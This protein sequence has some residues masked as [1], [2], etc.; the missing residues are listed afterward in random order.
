MIQRRPST[1][2]NSRRLGRFGNI[3]R[4][5]TPIRI[6]RFIEDLPPVPQRIRTAPRSLQIG[7]VAPGAYPIRYTGIAYRNNNNNNNNNNFQNRAATNIRNVP[8][9]V[10]NIGRSLSV[11]T[12]QPVR[13][14]NLL[15]VPLNQF[16]GQPQKLPRYDFPKVL[17]KKRIQSFTVR[18]KEVQSR[19]VAFPKHQNKIL[20]PATFPQTVSHRNDNPNS[21]IVQTVP[22][23][24]AQINIDAGDGDS[25]TIVLQARMSGNTNPVVKT[26]VQPGQG[27]IIP[28]TNV[29]TVTSSDV[30][31]SQVQIQ[32]NV[33]AIQPNSALP[34]DT[35]H[36]D[37]VDAFTKVI[38]SALVPQ[39]NVA[40]SAYKSGPVINNNIKHTPTSPIQHAQNAFKT[41]MVP[42]YTGMNHNSPSHIPGVMMGSRFS[43]YNQ[44]GHMA[45]FGYMNPWMSPDMMQEMMFGDTT[46]PPDGMTT[47]ATPE[48]ISST[49]ITENT[50]MIPA[51]ISDTVVDTAVTVPVATDVTKLKVET[52]VNDKIAS[53]TMMVPSVDVGTEVKIQI[54]QAETPVNV[55]LKPPNKNT[56]TSNAD[57]SITVVEVPPESKIVDTVNSKSSS[58][59]LGSLLVE[60]ALKK[61][62]NN[63][64]VVE[65]KPE[66]SNVPAETVKVEVKQSTFKTEELTNVE[67]KNDGKE[68]TNIEI[69]HSSSVLDSKGKTDVGPESLPKRLDV[70]MRIKTPTDVGKIIEQSAVLTDDVKKHNDKTSNNSLKVVDKSEKLITDIAALIKKSKVDLKHLSNLI[71]EKTYPKVD[72]KP[73]KEPVPTAEQ[74]GI[75]LK[76]QNKDRSIGVKVAP[77]PPS[78][79]FTHM[80][81]DIPTIPPVPELLIVNKSTV[82]PLI[83]K[84]LIFTRQPEI[85]RTLRTILTHKPDALKEAMATDPTPTI[86]EAQA[87]LPYTIGP[88]KGSLD[89]KNTSQNLDSEIIKVS[90]VTSK[91][92]STVKPDIP[93]MLNAIDQ[94]VKMQEISK[95]DGLVD[96]KDT[97]INVNSD[98]HQQLEDLNVTE[99]ITDGDKAVDIAKYLADPSFVDILRGMLQ[100]MAGKQEVSTYGYYNAPETTTFLPEIT[101]TSY[102]VSTTEEYELEDYI[103]EAP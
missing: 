6:N 4:E 84:G 36:Q 101:T 47:T 26:I 82:P 24:T 57:R 76:A 52:N 33:K 63:V 37:L 99:G 28:P 97:N 67:T 87:T 79:E 65:I 41:N 89:D 74:L 88:V 10:N 54:K 49:I 86:N 27:G 21:V 29:A 69:G 13:T 46:D 50:T 30:G 12:R 44:F 77:T 72:I 31:Q 11:Q 25:S 45:G 42:L 95:D 9:V 40:N 5:I 32:G 48:N 19:S 43:P 92:T 16:Q 1:G 98:L 81:R 22:S 35:L 78:G 64:T 20:A 96:I 103:T 66:I 17:S 62:V 80:P 75:K 100:R 90:T 60:Q 39:S 91:I 2:L 59:K 102:P 93:V 73:A 23:H 68:R 7:Q 83:P 8:R 18:S 38:E 70:D 61:A 51:T 56:I 53:E 15:P 94:D 85:Y 34:A 71:S 55:V 14:S 58:D 3:Q